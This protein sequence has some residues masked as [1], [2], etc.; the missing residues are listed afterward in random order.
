MYSWLDEGIA[1]LNFWEQKVF[2]V[3]L[4]LLTPQ[5]ISSYIEEYQCDC[6][7]MC[8]RAISGVGGLKPSICGR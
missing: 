1:E 5:Q 7:D 4:D 6:Q 8:D 3:L 2:T